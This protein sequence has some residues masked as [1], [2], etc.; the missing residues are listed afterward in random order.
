M[1]RLAAVHAQM[2]HLKESGEAV[3][4][5]V[6]LGLSGFARAMLLALALRAATRVPQHSV[7]TV[8][9]NVPG[10]QRAL[11]AAGRRMLE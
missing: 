2:E 1:Q 8:T 10:P 5:D 9:T 7:N 3:A 11:F 6:L 4:R